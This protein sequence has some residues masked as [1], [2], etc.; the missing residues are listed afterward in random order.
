MKITKNLKNMAH[1]AVRQADKARELL[2]SSAGKKSATSNMPA[3]A[4]R[5]RPRKNAEP[6]T[7][8]QI[9]SLEAT[10]REYE[11]A[12][13][14]ILRL[15]EFFS[16]AWGDGDMGCK[17]PVTRRIGIDDTINRMQEL[18]TA[19]R[20]EGV[21]NDDIERILN[22]L[23]KFAPA[24]FTFLEQPEVPPDNNPAERALRHFVV[25][26]KV[27]G[28]F[29]TDATLRVYIMHLS[30]YQ[31]YLK[32]GIDYNKIL[33]LLLQG[34]TRKIMLLLGLPGSDPPPDAVKRR[35]P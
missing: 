2:E 20:D 13:S 21:A 15:H 1:D 14:Q 19:I 24:L 23:E 26:R 11:K 17:S 33:G 6:L 8:E 18:I 9:A 22:R 32:Y 12:F 16:Q 10:V 34:E 29:I 35:G 27:S 30:L 5:G 7:A 25:Q 28:N 3:R 4:P 31:A